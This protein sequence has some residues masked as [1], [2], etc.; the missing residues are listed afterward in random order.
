LPNI[1]SFINEVKGYQSS[2]EVFNPWR[3]YNSEY[4][5]GSSAPEIR[6]AHLESFLRLRAGRASCILIAEAVGYQGGRFSGIP[7]VSERIFIMSH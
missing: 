2:R 1:K 4:D 5:I 7:L 3:D 6:T